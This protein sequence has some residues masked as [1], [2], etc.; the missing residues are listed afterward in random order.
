MSKYIT[1]Y[2]EALIELSAEAQESDEPHWMVKG[3]KEGVTT[4]HFGI[5]NLKNMWGYY[6]FYDSETLTK[7]IKVVPATGIG[8]VTVNENNVSVEDG[9]IVVEDA[10]GLV[11]VY[12]VGGT[13]VKSVKAG[14]N[15]VEIA[16]PGR[17]IY[18]VKVNNKT[19]KIAL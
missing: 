17:G 13:L 5:E 6:N 3:L 8:S 19:T 15:R 14:G 9:N 12:T 2:D 16:V 10:M 11:S 4:L 7:T 18:V 1:D